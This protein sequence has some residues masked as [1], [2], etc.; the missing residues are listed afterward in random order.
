MAETMV[1][2][3]ALRWDASKAA[4]WA[5]RKAATRVA[6]KAQTSESLWE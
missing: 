2:T 6:M 4:L 3:S 5:V 1:V